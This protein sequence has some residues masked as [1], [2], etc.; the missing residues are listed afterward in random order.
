M[1]EERR[2]TLGSFE[3]EEMGEEGEEVRGKLTEREVD[4]GGMAGHFF[5]SSSFFLMS[6]MRNNKEGELLR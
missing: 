6:R 5:S 4:R 3:D 2:G 1:V